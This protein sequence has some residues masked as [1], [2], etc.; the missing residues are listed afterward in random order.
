MSDGAKWEDEINNYED[1]IFAMLGFANFYRY[2]DDTHEMR[3]GV[4]VM[5]GWSFAPAEAQESDGNSPAD[6]RPVTPD[7]AILL[8]AG[9]G[10]VAEVKRSFPMDRSRWMR[11][12]EQL[13]RY[14][15]DL[16]GW[17]SSSGR[18]SSHDIVLLVHQSRARRVTDYYREQSAAG[19][20]RF[21]R[22]FVI[23]EFNRSAERQ[24]YFFFRKFEGK[25][26][27]PQVDMRL[28]DG[29]QVPMIAGIGQ[30]SMVKLYDS[31]PPMPYFLHIIWQEIITPKAEAKKPLTE[32]RRKQKV[33]VVVDVDELTQELRDKFSFKALFGGEHPRQP[34]IPQREW[35][36]AACEQLIAS[37][38]AEWVESS[39]G[40]KLKVFFQR[41]DDVLAVFKG[42]CGQPPATTQRVLFEDAPGE[43]RSPERPAP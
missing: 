8:E 22:P 30:Y 21:V 25:L 20:T 29:V 4:S 23:V 17:P 15:A 18:V 9:D 5:Q 33:E 34:K 16:V 3:L 32:L 14:D 42:M 7:L 19:R 36:R 10:I 38:F 37:K 24:P 2:N 31:D 35:V 41:L 27:E 1:T 11:H 12:F 40:L 39:D 43:E 26:S 28:Y 13:M 6:A